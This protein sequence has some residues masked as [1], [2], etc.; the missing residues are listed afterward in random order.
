MTR[1]STGRVESP[2]QKKANFFPETSVKERIEA[3]VAER[4]E[5]NERRQ[6]LILL[7]HETNEGTDDETSEGEERRGEKERN[8][9]TSKLTDWTRVEPS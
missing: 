2:S 7:P 5:R 8:T 3:A 9:R 6:K 1:S 4:E